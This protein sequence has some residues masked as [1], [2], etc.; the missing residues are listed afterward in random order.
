[1]VGTINLARDAQ[2]ALPTVSAPL[3]IAATS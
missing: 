1:V 2:A 3:L